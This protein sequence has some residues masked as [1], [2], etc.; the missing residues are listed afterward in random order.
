MH[1]HVIIRFYSPTE[2]R[3][4]G[5]Q[6]RQRATRCQRAHSSGRLRVLP[7]PYARRD[8]PKQRRRRHPRLHLPRDSQSKRRSTAFLSCVV[9]ILVCK[10]RVGEEDWEENFPEWQ[11]RKGLF[12]YSKVA[13]VEELFGC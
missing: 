4:P 13:K 8:R 6:T 2:V 9:G 7:P 12:F 5:H 3:A 10:G 11:R 1:F